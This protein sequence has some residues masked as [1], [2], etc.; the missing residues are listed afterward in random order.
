MPGTADDVLW[1]L[2]DNQNTVRD[3]V[4][5]DP[6]A[7]ATTTIEHRQYD[8]Y[9]NLA[10]APVLDHLFAYTARPWDKATALQNNLNRWYDPEV[11]RWLSEDPIEFEA[12]DANIYRYCENGPVNGVDSSGLEAINEFHITNNGD[13]YLNGRLYYSAEQ[14][15]DG[16]IT[17]KFAYQ[18]TRSNTEEA[19]ILWGKF[20]RP[21]HYTAFPEPPDR[22]E[23]PS[24]MDENGVNYSR[25]ESRERQAEYKEELNKW[26]SDFDEWANPF[27]TKGGKVVLWPC[28]PALF[29]AKGV[30]Y[31]GWDPA[32][33]IDNDFAAVVIQKYDHLGKKIGVPLISAQWYADEARKGNL[34]KSKEVYTA[35]SDEFDM[36]VS[37]GE[38]GYIKIWLVYGDIGGNTKVA[39]TSRGGTIAEYQITYS[40]L[41]GSLF[42]SVGKVFVH[43]NHSEKASETGIDWDQWLW[44]GKKPNPKKSEPWTHPEEPSG[45][46]PRLSD[47]Q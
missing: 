37:D 39:E 27:T 13:T 10:A 34:D 15:S 8:T 3:L 38:N 41:R 9:G 40:Y 20:A 29:N 31:G 11:G 5:Y 22:P 14:N 42:S 2:V 7:D 16:L 44:D 21:Y 35:I 25:E 32:K 12:E 1:A 28:L 24:K 6:A 46:S 26:R 18:L 36:H 4:Q 23:R 45:A 33:R 17:L 30:R 47:C 19:R 43:L